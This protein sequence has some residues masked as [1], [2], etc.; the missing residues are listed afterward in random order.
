MSI[1]VNC[2]N[3]FMNLKPFHHNKTTHE[4]GH[5]W[6]TE[7]F[8]AVVCSD[9]CKEEIEK[10]VTSQKR[11]DGDWMT[12]RPFPKREEEDGSPKALTDKQ[13]GTT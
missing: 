5:L 10:L 2:Y 9:K 6:N 8:L 1:C 4:V 3:V 12:M 7:P 11:G 13:F